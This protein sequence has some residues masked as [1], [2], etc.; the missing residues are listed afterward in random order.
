MYLNLF[1][2]GSLKKTVALTLL[3]LFSLAN[4]S[5]AGGEFEFKPE[6]ILADQQ[7]VTEPSRE[8]EDIKFGGLVEKVSVRAK[9][10]QTISISG[11]TVTASSISFILAT[12]GTCSKFE[13]ACTINMLFKKD[14]KNVKMKGQEQCVQSADLVQV[15]LPQRLKGQIKRSSESADLLSFQFSPETLEELKPTLEA[16]ITQVLADAAK[17]NK[18][19]GI[20]IDTVF[21]NLVGKDVV[22][23]FC[24][25]VD[26]MAYKKKK[27]LAETMKL[28]NGVLSQEMVMSTQGGEYPVF[29]DWTQFIFERTEND[30][31]MALPN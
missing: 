8:K 27:I 10:I 25:R 17:N 29:E 16:T 12:S 6:F 23:Q 22:N 24:S 7:S 1:N 13:T 14:K 2:S 15:E 4:F 18:G 11:L 21:A 26:E 19:K 3:S 5:Y 20:K 9:S 28:L 31:L 30:S